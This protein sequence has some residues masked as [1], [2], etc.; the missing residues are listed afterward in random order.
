MSWYY[1]CLGM[2]FIPVGLTFIPLYIYF[3]ERLLILFY[4]RLII[5]RSYLI[6]RGLIIY[7]QYR[8]LPCLFL[9]WNCTKGY[10][11]FLHLFQFFLTV[12]FFVKSIWFWQDVCMPQCYIYISLC[13][14]IICFEIIKVIRR[15]L[16]HISLKASSTTN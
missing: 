3:S 10:T 16:C 9:F 15:H 5:L 1:P 11:K 14:T 8:F 7:Y 4:K 2:I 12:F 13:C 6:L